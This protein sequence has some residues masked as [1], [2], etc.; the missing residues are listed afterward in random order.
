MLAVCLAGTVVNVLLFLTFHAVVATPVEA[1][2]GTG[3]TQHVSALQGAVF[4]PPF[5]AG[6]SASSLSE[7]KAVYVCHGLI[8]FA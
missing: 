4:T 8:R 7:A 6:P 2:A 3:N 1:S 5:T